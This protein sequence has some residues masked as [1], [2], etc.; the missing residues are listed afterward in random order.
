[1]GHNDE[2]IPTN[3]LKDGKI[4]AT[5]LKN[6]RWG[7]VEVWDDESGEPN[8]QFYVVIQSGM[9]KKSANAFADRLKAGLGVQ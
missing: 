7:V 4:V 6:R 1:M 9:D 2:N 5:Q 3:F 8:S